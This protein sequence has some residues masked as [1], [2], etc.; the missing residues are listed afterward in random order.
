MA[1]NVLLCDPHIAPTRLSKLTASNNN[2]CNK[3]MSFECCTHVFT[4]SGFSFF[5][6]LSRAI[7][8][9]LIFRAL[10]QRPEWRGAW[11][12]CPVPRFEFRTSRISAN[13]SLL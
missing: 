5:F 10:L 1:H 11:Q 9:F 12:R 4:K 6:F 2:Y 3:D 8:T 7:N 13:F